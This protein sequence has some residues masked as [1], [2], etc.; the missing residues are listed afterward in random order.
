MDRNIVATDKAPGAAGPYSQGVVGEGLVF[1]AGMM[2]LD[3]KTGQLVS[4][5]VGDQTRQALANLQSILEAAGTSLDRAVKI[6]VFL[7]DIGAFSQMNAAYTEFFP[8]EP[9]ARTTVQVGPLPKGG[10]VEIDAIA[11]K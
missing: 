9:P 8:S 10:L 11:L 6:T 3:P 4:E 2:G 5:D 7:T 1:T